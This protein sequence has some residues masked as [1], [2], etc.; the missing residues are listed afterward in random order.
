MTY[1]AGSYGLTTTESRSKAAQIG[2]RL[3]DISSPGP[4]FTIAHAGEERVEIERGGGA[5]ALALYESLTYHA[6]VGLTVFEQA[7]RRTDDLAGRPIPTRSN[8]GVDEVAVVLVEAEGHVPTHGP[9]M[10]ASGSGDAGIELV[11]KIP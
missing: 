6:H 7:Q 3:G 8:L 5:A 1:R 2:G 11:D 9:R 10:P 4:R